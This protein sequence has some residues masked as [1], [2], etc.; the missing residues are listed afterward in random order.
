[1]RKFLSAY[2]RWEKDPSQLI[3]YAETYDSL[4]L[5]PENR[6]AWERLPETLLRTYYDHGVQGMPQDLPDDDSP[7]G[8]PLKER[9]KE[10]LNAKSSF[11]GIEMQ[12]KAPLA[13]ENTFSSQNS[14]E[15]TSDSE[16]DQ[17]QKFEKVCP[18][19]MDLFEQLKTT[20]WYKNL[21][22]DEDDQ[23][24][25]NEFG[26]KSQKP[27]NCSQS[28]EDDEALIDIYGRDDRCDILSKE[29]DEEHI[30]TAGAARSM[31]HGGPSTGRQN[32]ADL[33][34][35]HS[36]D[37]D[38]EVVVTKKRRKPR[39]KNSLREMM[40]MMDQ[41]LEGQAANI[42]RVPGMDFD[43]PELEKVVSSNIYKARP[44][45]DNPATMMLHSLGLN[46]C[47]KK[48]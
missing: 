22:D 16:F 17:S 39:A 28:S 48:L 15:S 41:E 13:T 3:R 20:D 45:V 43:D 10:F 24:G 38:E 6:D 18:D 46:V 47:K 40:K 37:S 34:N 7:L 26:A 29:V 44:G 36:S 5:K 11:E 32:L 30:I 1:M 4:D 27:V 8:S 2:C 35:L 19:L 14:S 23:F 25:M 12:G 9:L 31:L 21:T 42:G 33:M